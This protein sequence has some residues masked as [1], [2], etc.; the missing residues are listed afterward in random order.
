[1][2][3]LA[4]KSTIE[5]T[6]GEKGG[7]ASL[8]RLLPSPGVTRLRQYDE[9]LRHPIR[10]G[11]SLASC[12]LIHTA[13]TAGTSRVA[14]GPLCLVGSRTGAPLR[15]FSLFVAPRFLWECLT[16]RIVSRFPTPASSNPA[17]RFPALGFPV[18]FASRVME[19][20]PPGWLSAD[21][22]TYHPVVVKQTEC[23]VEP[24]RTPPLPAESFAPS[25]T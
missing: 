14:F 24:L 12:Q 22:S 17:C 6:L 21:G 18:C 20:I 13:I 7:L 1:M 16:S 25:R 3:Q 9:P 19:L 23:V 15:R 2:N 11:L 10:P 8:H 4:A 5:T